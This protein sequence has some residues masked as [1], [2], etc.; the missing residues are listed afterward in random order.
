VGKS[1]ELVQIGE[2]A[3]PDGWSPL[4]RQLGVRAFGINAWTAAEAGGQLI[5]VHDEAPSGHEEL[6]LVSVGRATFTVDGEEVDARAGAVVFVADPAVQRGAVARESGT[7]VVSVGGAPGEAYA[8]RSWELN[9]DMLPLFDAGKFAEV[10]E[11]L[12]DAIDHYDDRHVVLFNLACAEAQLGQVDEAIG[13]L[14][15]GIELRSELAD[16][17][18]NDDDLAPL[19]ADPRYAEIVGT[20]G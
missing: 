9:R 6:Y 4:R 8:V 13:H 7:V 5:P 12:L 17:A 18:R 14:R 19:R 16:W 3:R 11:L 20:P 10:K 1:F 2:I 15:E